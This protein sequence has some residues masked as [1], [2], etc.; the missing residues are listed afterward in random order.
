MFRGFWWCFYWTINITV[1]AT[2]RA[3]L[4]ADIRKLSNKIKAIRCTKKRHPCSVLVTGMTPWLPWLL[5]TNRCIGVSWDRSRAMGLVM[6]A[7]TWTW[8]FGSIEDL[9]I[10][11]RVARNSFHPPIIHFTFNRFSLLINHFKVVSLRGI[12][13]R[14]H[15]TYILYYLTMT[16]C[17]LTSFSMW[18]KLT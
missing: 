8:T 17:L 2:K 11:P 10:F 6:L 4:V 3:M 13:C 7:W 16:L 12:I 9:N 5:S 15:F 18:L 1:I 14:K